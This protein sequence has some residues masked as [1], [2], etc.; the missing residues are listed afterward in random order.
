[1][2]VLV[3]Y[4]SRH[5]S[6]KGIAERVAT[7][8][9][10]C[11]HEAT[12]RGADEADDIERHDA[13]VI[14][15]SAYFFHWAKAPTRL[16]RQHAPLLSRRPTWL[17]SS[18]PLGTDKVDAQGRDMLAASV[19]REFAELEPLI[20]PRDARIFFGAYDPTA[21]PV[22]VLERITR[23]MPAARD[24]LPAGDFRDWT[25]I[26]DWAHGIGAELATAET[27]A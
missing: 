3:A 27:G 2:K 22:G 23:M 17:F 24:A 1:M 6:T 15:G 14:G 19:P 25:A 21:R 18:G 20:Q 11:G 9:T 7:T 8:L 26:D 13:F 12:L 4:A 10:R 5:G 16:V